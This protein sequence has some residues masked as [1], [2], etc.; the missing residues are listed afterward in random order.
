MGDLLVH[1]QTG[2][3]MRKE[4]NKIAGWIW[5]WERMCYMY[6]AEDRKYQIYSGE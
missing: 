4:I 2:T 1:D 6:Q 3:A 5:V